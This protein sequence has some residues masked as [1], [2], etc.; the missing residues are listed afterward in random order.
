MD[1]SIYKYP[2]TTTMEVSLLECDR[3]WRLAMVAR[4]CS[5]CLILVAIVAYIIGGGVAARGAPTVGVP[6][7]PPPPLPPLPS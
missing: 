5:N 7:P 1:E 6:L 4:L 2:C 3:C